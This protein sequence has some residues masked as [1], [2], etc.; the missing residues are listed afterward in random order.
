MVGTSIQFKEV[1]MKKFVFDGYHHNNR[2][3][4]P[5]PLKK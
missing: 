2:N 4:H 5:Q 1:R 3:H